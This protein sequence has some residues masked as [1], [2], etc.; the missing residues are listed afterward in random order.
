MSKSP[1]RLA[2]AAT[3]ALAGLACIGLYFG[4]RQLASVWRMA[5][6]QS[7]FV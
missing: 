2:F 1:D 4:L 5:G 7:V 6:G 3:L